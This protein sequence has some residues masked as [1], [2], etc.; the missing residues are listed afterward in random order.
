M[1]D[2]YVMDVSGLPDG[3]RTAAFVGREAISECFSFQVSLIV[4]ADDSFH[5]DALVGADARLAFGD[6]KP[7]D[8]PLCAGVVAGAELCHAT[9]AHVFVRLE[10]RPRLWRLS[11]GRHSRIWTDKAVPDVVRDVFDRAD[12]SAHELKLDGS[13]PE[14]VHVGQYHESDLAFVERRLEREGIF[15]YFE[16]TEAG[17]K[18]VLADSGGGIGESQRAA[19]HFRGRA[20]GDADASGGDALYRFASRKE[21]TSKSVQLRDYDYLHPALDLSGQ[22]APPRGLRGEVSLFGGNLLTPA[23]ATRLAQA[24]AERLGVEAERYTG[25]GF[26]RGLRSGCLLELDEHPVSEL[27]GKYLVT[28]LQHRGVDRGLM[29]SF[30]AWLDPD[31]TLAGDAD[32]H[33]YHV[34]LSAVRSAQAFRPALRRAVPTIPGLEYGLVDGPVDSDY[35]QI[36]EHGRYRTRLMF[37][38]ADESAG[39]NSAW[40]RMLQPHA[41]APEGWHLPLRKGTE[42]LIAFMAG[43]PDRPVIVGSVPNVVTPSPVTSS[44]ATQNVFQSG[45]LNRLEVEDQAGKQYVAL[46]SPPQKSTLHLGASDGAYAEGHHA[47]LRTD[48][49]ARVNAGANRHIT[50]G[51]EQTEDVGGDVTESY[52]STQTTHVFGA[53]KETID[54]GATQTI[55]GGETR[56]V[57]GGVT[58]SISGGE[59]RNIT[60]DQTESVSAGVTRTIGA[61]LSETVGA[62]ADF[63]VGGSQTETTA[64]ARAEKVGGNVSVTAGGSYDYTALGGVTFDTPG[65]LTILAP[66]GVKE[67]DENK[68]SEGGKALQMYAYAA[69]IVAGLSF[70]MTGIAGEVCGTKIEISMDVWEGGGCKVETIGTAIH[71]KAGYTL[72]GL[73]SA[74]S[75]GFINWT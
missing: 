53:W 18:L 67:V 50:V 48:G 73:L 51:G 35:A 19:C 32:P 31:G 37:D 20:L 11:L 28:E 57:S 65:G 63:I 44:N 43:D 6:A 40:L 46:Y 47:T 3:T 27:N 26:V 15:Y 39:H 25:A 13:Y 33:P 4:P 5:P 68:D 16:H 49:D 21:L 8:A 1:P 23:D 55:N 9:S 56:T 71:S 2:L 64:G 12:L 58:E 72:N 54:A 7:G 22:A 62:N 75:F 45:G 10:L 29:R 60:G 34:E 66:G 52:H 24:R 61:T 36:D 38:E 59:T 69:E 74:L 41:G 70:E 30:G 17:D 42:V 14:L